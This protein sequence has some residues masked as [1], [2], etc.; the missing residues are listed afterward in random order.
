MRVVLQG[1]WKFW[2][3]LTLA[4][5]TWCAVGQEIG[6]TRE[7][8]HHGVNLNLL[9]VPSLNFSALHLMQ[10]PFQGSV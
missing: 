7:P 5:Q 3:V 8:Q 9:V 4:I 10:L 2:D 6:E 1:R